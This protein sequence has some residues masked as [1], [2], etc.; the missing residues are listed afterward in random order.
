M[1]HRN[2]LQLFNVLI[3]LCQPVKLLSRVW[4]FAIPWIVAYQAPPSMEFSRR[5]YWSGLPFPSPGDLPDPGIKPTSPA[6]QADTLPPELP[7]KYIIIL[8]MKRDSAILLTWL[9]R[10]ESRVGG[11]DGQESACNAGDL[12]SF[13]G[14]HRSPGGEHG[15]PLQNSCLENPPG[16]R[17][18]A[19]YSP[20][21]HKESNRTERLNRAHLGCSMC[22]V[23]VTGMYVQ[24]KICC[25]WFA[26]DTQAG[27]ENSFFF[28]L[29][30]WIFRF[31]YNE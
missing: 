29:S 9:K 20:W 2:T 19:S 1:L 5:E 14:L 18:L 22:K 3:S 13:P 24:R 25:S 7:G 8:D 27:D 12:D 31:F 11:S 30:I 15:N 21:G 6:L 28:F 26:D 17:S 16:Q 10:V 23:M 4:L